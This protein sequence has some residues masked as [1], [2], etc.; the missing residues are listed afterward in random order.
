MVVD[1]DKPM[2]KAIELSI[3]FIVSLNVALQGWSLKQIIGLKSDMAAIQAN[4]FTARDGMLTTK[5][6]GEQVA[7]I[8]KEISDIRQDIAKKANSTDVPPPEVLRR[9]KAIEEKLDVIYERIHA[10][11]IPGVGS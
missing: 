4:R 7:I 1:R 3:M 9:M 8:W 11:A 6:I 10:I 2:W 5:L